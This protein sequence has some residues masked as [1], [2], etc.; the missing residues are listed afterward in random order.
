MKS[1]NYLLI[2]IALVLASISS[3][4]APRCNFDKAI[5]PEYAQNFLHINSE[6]DD[7][8][9]DMQITAAYKEFSLIFSTNRKSEGADFSFIHYNGRFDVSLYDGTLEI[10]EIY[11]KDLDF[12]NIINSSDN[13]FG[14]YRINNSSEIINDSYYSE[15]PETRF[16]F[17]NDKK[18]N[19][20]IYFAKITN[21]SVTDSVI[22]LSQ[23]NSEYDD[24]YPSIIYDSISKK[25]TM[26][27]CSNRKGNFDIFSVTS[28]PDKHIEDCDS[29]SITSISDINS[30]SDDKCPFIIG[31]TMIFSSDRS[32]GKGGFDLWY[33]KFDGTN[34]SEPKNLGDIYNSEYDEYRPIVVSCEESMW[35]SII[36]DLIIFSS[37]RPEGLGG[38]DLYYSGIKRELP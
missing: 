33:T 13:E 3:C 17:A 34:W 31:N 29:L 32:G 30:V 6:Y 4:Y 2:F 12:L 35:S 25:E 1:R 28:Q 18:N 23:I 27:F 10:E 19:L 21:N 14:P 11:I 5:I 36:N 22:F 9:S 38:F 24:A 8:N 15:Y 26:V 37:N 20:D 16:F 7:Y